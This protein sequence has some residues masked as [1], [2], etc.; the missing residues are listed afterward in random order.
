MPLPGARRSMSIALPGARAARVAFIQGGL[1]FP[2]PGVV[3]DLDF[4][5]RRYYWNGALR[6]EG[7]F[8][9]F[10]LNGATFEARGL[11]ISTC[12]VNPNITISL[13]ALGLTMPP[14]VFGFGG[15]LLGTPAGNRYFFQVD[16][17]TDNERFLLFGNN[18]PTVV[19]QTID[20]GVLQSQSFP[21]SIGSSTQ[22][23]GFAFGAQL[24][25]VKTAGNGTGAAQDTAA[26]MPTVTTLR[27]GCQVTAAP[28][29][30]PA[31]LSRMWIYSAVKPQAEINQLSIDVRD[32][33]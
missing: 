17:G 18:T 3:I 6:T 9:T 22:R 12:S 14:C 26:T 1:V 27:L 11:N 24:N 15:Y 29:F 16:D 30:P 21:G 20:G 33:P 5:R 32:A 8:T 4:I 23:F 13:A 28:T 31:V 10:V 19:S 7:D 25:D 2:Q